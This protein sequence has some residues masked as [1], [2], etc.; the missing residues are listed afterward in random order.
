MSSQPPEGS[1]NPDESL[2]EPDAEA[3]AGPE[4][5]PPLANEEFPAAPPYQS[6]DV[7]SRPAVKRYEAKTVWLWLTLTGIGLTL[8][9]ALTLNLGNQLTPNG[10]GVLILTA[11]IIALIAAGIGL[12]RSKDDALPRNRSRWMG[13]LIGAGLSLTCGGVCFGALSSLSGI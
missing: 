9:I 13:T 6:Y 12:N 7:P 4:F 8:L 3:A 1:P 2:P 5:V 10:I 11:P